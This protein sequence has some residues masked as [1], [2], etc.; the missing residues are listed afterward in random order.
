MTD[1]IKKPFNPRQSYTLNP[2]SIID[3]DGKNPRCSSFD[4]VYFMPGSGL[5][6]VDHVFLGGNGLPT[7]WD[8]E[9]PALYPYPQPSGA[10]TILELGFGTGL[11]VF[12]TVS[13]WLK[14]GH[15]G[16]WRQL[17]IISTELQPIPGDQLAVY[18]S[19]HDFDEGF[20]TAFL[21]WY[22]ENLQGMF[23]LRYSRGRHVVVFDLLAGNALAML[24]ELRLPRRSFDALFLDGFAPKKN[25]ALWSEEI[26]RAIAA[27]SKPG[28]TRFATFT[29]ARLVRDNLEAAG[30]GWQKVPGI[31]GKR[32]NL[33]GSF[34]MPDDSWAQAKDGQ[35][36][37]RHQLPKGAHIAVIGS[38]LAGCQAAYALAQRG[39]KVTIIDRAAKVAAGASGNHQGALYTRITKA[40]TEVSSFYLRAFYF[41]RQQLAAIGGSLKAGIYQPSPLLSWLETAEAVADAESL[42]ARHQFSPK[43]LS[44]HQE[45]GRSWLVNHRSA[46]VAPPALCE[47]LLSFGL[48]TAAITLRLG[49]PVTGLSR[50]GAGWQVSLGED[51]LGADAVVL[52]NSF[53][54]SELWPLGFLGI[55]AIRGQVSYIDERLLPERQ[56]ILT[57]DRYLLPGLRGIATAGASFNLYSADPA[58]SAEDAA[59]NLQAAGELLGRDLSP[60]AAV[61]GRVSFRGASRDYL[62]IVGPVPD[63]AAFEEAF[64]YLAKD[65]KKPVDLSRAQYVPRLFVTL[66]HGSRGLT[67]TPLSGEILAAMVAGEPAPVEG[68]ILSSL[69]PERFV[70]RSLMRGGKG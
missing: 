24:R 44:L 11:N 29:A 35:L 38:G 48:S 40:P 67:S 49:E 37:D 59:A 13:Q 66:G 28:H 58:L 17:H 32:H 6:E 30:F 2:P 34:R 63:T 8:Q 16:P 54:A 65:A 15:A 64:G 70:L 9:A 25:P 3:Q 50:S 27:G 53:E 55:K 5:A 68:A 60:D 1:R 39:F 57:A 7:A 69:A 23:R 22:P 10:F 43:F 4:D 52:A 56:G 51:R 26:F 61:G 12:R 14:R 42:L 33:V 41:A 20:L 46:A 45:G 62:P 21:R 47:R 31:R 18:A 19:Q 36:S